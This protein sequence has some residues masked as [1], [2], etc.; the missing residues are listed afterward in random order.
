MPLRAAAR[1]THRD[2]QEVRR[3]IMQA[4]PMLQR[5]LRTRGTRSRLAACRAPTSTSPCTPSSFVAFEV[6]VDVAFG[7]S[8]ACTVLRVHHFHYAVPARRFFASV[9]AMMS[10]MYGAALCIE[11]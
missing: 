11:R 10:K 9:S 3:Q 7:G 2:P 8:D 4:A 1:A 5:S 6:E